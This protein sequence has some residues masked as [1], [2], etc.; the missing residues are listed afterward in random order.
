[1]KLL[2]K[3]K[4]EIKIAAVY[5]A[6]GISWILFSD[7]FFSTFTSNQELLM[8]INII[9][10]FAY[11]FV[12]SVL[13]YGLVKR[14]LNNLSEVGLL[15]K[16]RT[17]RLEM[18]NLELEKANNKLE[19]S[20]MK[21]RMAFETSPDAITMIRIS[22]GMILSANQG[23][24]QI[25]GFEKEAAENHTT[26]QLNIWINNDSYMNFLKQLHEKGFVENFEAKFRTCDNREL[27][28]LISSAVMSFG[29]ENFAIN[30]L[31]DIS[32]RKKMEIEL[33]AAKI[34]AEEGDQLKS[35]FLQNMSHEVR[36][37]LN[38]IVGF[39]RLI[40]KCGNDEDKMILYADLIT[41]SS[42]KLIGIITDVI[43]ISRFQTDLV[44]FEYENFDIDI[45][46]NALKNKFQRLATEKHLLFVYET[47]F[48]NE[49]VFV[50]TD[51]EKLQSILIHLLDNAIKFTNFGQVKLSCHRADNKIYFS[52]T[53]TGIGIEASL[54]DAIFDAFRQ[55]ETGICRN[56]GGNG[57][58]L[59]LSKKYVEG[60]GGKIWM[61]SELNFG[62]TFSFYLPL[63]NQ[64][65]ETETS[66]F[67]KTKR[68]IKNILIAEDEF[69]NYI[70]L[71]QILGLDKYKIWHAKNG[72]EAV[73]ICQKEEIDLIF[74]DIKMP[75]LDGISAALSIRQDFPDMPIIAQT[76]YG[77]DY[78][79]SEFGKVFYDYISK[80]IDATELE[81]IMQKYVIK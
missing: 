75:V 51:K 9:K 80:P 16:Q 17:E 61:E 48:E 26:A 13:L 14:H 21:F 44:R 24:C 15:V 38:A 79:I 66:V 12:T 52:V 8:K 5:F 36:T 42:E 45:L 22:D 77:M 7:T 78:E 29:N 33:L 55:V 37:P 20:E 70:Y 32:E 81:N 35:S 56:Y 54:H 47:D 28:V 69:T 23:F 43:E 49:D 73:S 1:M 6:L 63:K 11:V 10:G 74:M 76:S 40:S 27:D 59:T 65:Q 30:I 34:K 31:K 57:L 41:Q 50:N 62:S 2:R 58:G 25:F 4:F 53:D 67:S 68:V 71:S 39:S 72:E 3:L 60:L 64:E 18:Q 19:Q 46:L